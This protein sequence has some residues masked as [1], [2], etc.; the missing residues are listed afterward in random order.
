MKKLKKKILILGYKNL[1]IIYFYI[2][3][4]SLSFTRNNKNTIFGKIFNL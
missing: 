2:L 3:T 4:Y 1:I